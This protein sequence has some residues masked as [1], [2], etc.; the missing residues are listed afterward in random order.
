MFLLSYESTILV[1]QNRKINRLYFIEKSFITK[2]Q[3]I[4]YGV[5]I[6]L[7]QGEIGTTWA[8]SEIQSRHFI[9][10]ILQW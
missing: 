4:N 9:Q 10:P 5:Y 1:T 2:V 6:N 8:L 7:V 3:F